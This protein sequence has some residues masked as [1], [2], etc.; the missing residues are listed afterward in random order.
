VGAGLF[1]FPASTLGIPWIAKPASLLLPIK[2]G[3]PL[4]LPARTYS[5]IINKRRTE[6]NTKSELEQQKIPGDFK[7]GVIRHHF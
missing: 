5:H 7:C 3:S 2:D 4:P 1:G 6:V